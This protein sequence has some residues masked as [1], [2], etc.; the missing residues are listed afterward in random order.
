MYSF[1][2]NFLQ[3]ALIIFTPTP[4]KPS[5]IH[6]Y[7]PPDN[8]PNPVCSA[9]I[10]MGAR[11]PLELGWP[12]RVHNLKDC[13]SLRSHQQSRVWAN[14]CLPTPG[15]NV[16]QI[17]L[18]QVLRGQPQLLWLPGSCRV[19]T[20]VP[21]SG[22]P[23]PRAD[24]SVMVPGPGL[25]AIQRFQLWLRSLMISLHLGQLYTYCILFIYS[26]P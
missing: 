13:F 18:G 23:L 14:K 11:P 3:H 10:F 9:H 12:T 8:P 22:P 6:P 7:W 25:C 26:F 19:Q 16:H 2:K 17:D 1:L 15:W 21:H 5:Q 24:S 20:S 4:P